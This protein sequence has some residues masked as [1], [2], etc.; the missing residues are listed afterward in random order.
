[1]IDDI[2]LSGLRENLFDLGRCLITKN[3]LNFCK[4]HDICVEDF[5]HRHQYGDWGDLNEDDKKIN[6]NAIKFKQQ[7]FSSYDFSFGKINIITDKGHLTTT[8]LLPSDN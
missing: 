3:A 7:I 2:D 6:E 5:V 8:I 4:T 1:M